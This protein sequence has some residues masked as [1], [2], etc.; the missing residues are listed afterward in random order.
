[1][2]NSSHAANWK[3]LKALVSQDKYKNVHK[4][5]WDD[6]IVITDHHRTRFKITS[7]CHPYHVQAIMDAIVES[8]YGKAVYN[9]FTITNIVILSSL[10]L[11]F[12]LN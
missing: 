3:G 8:G 11:I 9:S 6:F 2:D 10:F 4:M 5:I 7:D 1:M 12:S